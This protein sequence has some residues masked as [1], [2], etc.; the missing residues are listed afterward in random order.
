MFQVCSY[1]TRDLSAVAEELRFH[2]VRYFTR[3]S[4]ADFCRAFN[5]TL[6]RVGL[7]IPNG[8]SVTDTRV[9][10]WLYF[11]RFAKYLCIVILRVYITL[12]HVIYVCSFSRNFLRA[13]GVHRCDKL[14]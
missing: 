4:L 2:I 9:T 3:V 10:C 8:S 1:H 13:S 5:A 12:H 14:E 11:P 6:P 7:E